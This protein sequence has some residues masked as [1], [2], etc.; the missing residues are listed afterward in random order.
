MEAVSFKKFNRLG[1]LFVVLAATCW[2]SGASASKFLFN[3][4]ISPFQLV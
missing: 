4:G 3:S 1:Y 2:A